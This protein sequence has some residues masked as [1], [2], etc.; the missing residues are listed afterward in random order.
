MSCSSWSHRHCSSI[1]ER[2]ERGKFSIADEHRAS[3]VA[4]RLISRLGA[5]FARRGVKRG[6]VILAAPSGELHA[7]PVAIAANLLRWR[8]FDVVEL[9]ADTPAEALAE[10]VVA[11]PDLVAVGMAC[12]TDGTSRAA[13][14]AIAW[15]A[16]PRPAYP[17]SSVGPP[18]PTPS[19]PGSSVPTCSRA[20]E[21]TRSCVAVESLVSH[22][23]TIH[24]GR[25]IWTVRRRR[26]CSEPRQAGLAKHELH[27]AHMALQE[28]RLAVGE[29]QGPETSELG[30]TPSRS[31]VGRV[32][33]EVRRPASQR[34]GVVPADVLEVDDPQIRGP[35]Q[36][37][38]DRGHRGDDS[39][40]GTPCG[41][42]SP[43]AAWPV[44]SCDRR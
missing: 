11:E 1:G 43:G 40:R 26:A 3:T 37:R 21:P 16:G 41:G 36:R 2:W 9:G 14:R 18:S 5:R 38:R 15:C 35:R 12:T 27:V 13:R 31:T 22:Q 10:T 7:A 20:G 32:R 17:Y 25:D 4:A 23:L 33:R 28:R 8:G 24:A 30:S 44:R 29:V 19:T 42:R 39:R 34:L 6:T